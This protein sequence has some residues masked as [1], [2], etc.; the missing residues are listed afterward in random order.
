MGGELT[1]WINLL[2]PDIMT[3]KLQATNIIIKPTIF[4]YSSGTIAEKFIYI[5]GTSSFADVILFRLPTILPEEYNMAA[6]CII[7]T[8]ADRHS[9]TKLPLIPVES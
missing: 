9:G 1:T 5:K 3:Q 6:E 7:W 4:N 2:P 8:K